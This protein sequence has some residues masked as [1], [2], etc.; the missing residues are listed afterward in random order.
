MSEV[1]PSRPTLQWLQA[2]RG[3]AAL[4]VVAYHA[5]QW[6]DD[7]FWVGAAG[8]DVFFVISGFI[9]W[10]V[11]SGEEA[12]PGVF[13]WR[14][15]TRVAP[16]YWLATGAV[17]ALATLWPTLLRQVTLSPAHVA[18]SLAFI[19]HIDPRGLPFPVLPPGWSLNYEAVFYGLFTLVL[20]APAALRFRLLLAAL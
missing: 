11:G 5:F 20:F 18:L 2:L 4:S 13:V 17:I 8:V 3:F 15:L 9:I 10:T 1:A 19:Q 7:R 16:A 12:S 14:R 6:I